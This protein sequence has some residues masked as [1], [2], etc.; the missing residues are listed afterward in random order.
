M[1]TGE[2]L[3]DIM[4]TVMAVEAVG[5]LTPPADGGH[6]AMPDCLNCGTALSGRFCHGCGQAADVH[7][8]LVAFGHD[9]LH[10][11][12]HLE[13]RIWRTVPMLV[14]RPGKLTRDYIA[15]Q[16]ARYV[17]PIAAFLFA[18]FL[19]F[20]AIH[21]VQPPLKFHADV[22][23]AAALTEQNAAIAGQV[24]ARAKAA[25]APDDTPAERAQNVKAID[26]TIAKKRANVA[27]L[28]Q[29]QKA[30]LTKA[31]PDLADPVKVTSS[32][33]WLNDALQR[34]MTN[35]E[36]LLYKIQA[37]AYKFS[38]ALIPLSVPMVWLLF[39]FSRR[40]RL[41]DHTVFVTYSLAFMMLLGGTLTLLSVTKV[42]I[43]ALAWLLVPP[44]HLYRQ[45]KDAYGLTRFGTLWRLGALLVFALFALSVFA[46]GLVMLGVSE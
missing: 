31:P 26:E 44:L 41:F 39:A 1:A 23:I 35:P 38:W 46:L 36:L 21:T 16:R 22:T 27:R 34:A 9:L 18:T 32:V 17:S 30:G 42:P 40:F 28:L 2:A 14:W 24:K 25:A 12:F 5:E 4:Q 6:R 3:G 29:F 8:T 13:G 20:A 37:S 10:G 11:V 43:L 19:L 15:G 33:P 45:L 7:R